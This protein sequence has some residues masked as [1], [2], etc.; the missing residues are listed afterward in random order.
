[1]ARYKPQIT[2][3]QWLRIEPLLPKY[4]PSPHGGRTPKSNRSCLE[5]ILWI[6]RTGARWKD[7]PKGLPS[8]STCWRRLRDW[9]QQGVWER[10]WQILLKELDAQGKLDWEEAIGDGTFSPAK[11]GANALARPSAARGRRSWSSAMGTES[12]SL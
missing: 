8:G 11:K 1:M 12:L 5:G 3:Q 10:V 7:M 4:E 9:K 6:L 2:E